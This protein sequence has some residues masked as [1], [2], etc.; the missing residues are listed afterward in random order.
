M[1]IQVLICSP[2]DL[3]DIRWKVGTGAYTIPIHPIEKRDGIIC[4]LLTDV[5]TEVKHTA[6]TVWCVYVRIIW[7]TLVI[8]KFRV[9]RLHPS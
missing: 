8:V 9:P 7:L 4:V 5:N 2:D 1:L 6:G 3:I